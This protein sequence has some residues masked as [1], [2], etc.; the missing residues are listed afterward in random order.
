M[1]ICTDR[2]KERLPISLSASARMIGAGK[3]S[4]SRVMLMENVFS[5][6]RQKLGDSKKRVNSRNPT[7]GL[8]HMPWMTL[9]SRNAIWAPTIGTY[10][11]MT[12]YAIGTSTSR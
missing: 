6:S 10:L 2:L 5:I 9:K 7:Q 1:T 11:K 12:K 8:P 3:P 4:S